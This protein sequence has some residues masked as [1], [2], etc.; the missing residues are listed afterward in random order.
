MNRRFPCPLCRASLDVR[1]SKKDKPYVICDPCGMQMFVRGP[2]GIAKL[3]ALIA[4]GERSNAFDRLAEMEKRYRKSCPECGK[5]FWISPEGAKTSWFDGE[6]TGF[7][8]PEKGC[9][10]VVKVGKK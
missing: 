3:D 10:G 7:K 9:D 1:D 2:G 4:S 6:L 5:S 8:C